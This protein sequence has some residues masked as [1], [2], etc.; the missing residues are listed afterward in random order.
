MAKITLTKEACLA[1]IPQRFP[2]VM[3]DNLLEY[4]EFRL[5]SSF[6]VVAENIFVDNKEFEAAGLIEHMAQS[7]ALHTG[8]QFFLK[9][10]PAP[11][12]YIGSIKSVEISRLPQLNEELTT[13][14]TILH[15]F[16]GVTL[17][18]IKSSVNGEQI[19]QSQMKTV[20][21]A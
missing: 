18:D 16:G 21:A 17:V 19:A 11:T 15:E 4:D 10:E 12:G 14:V 7:V 2:F 8:Y 5:V 9:H 13:E 20:I 3:I 6:R 1:L